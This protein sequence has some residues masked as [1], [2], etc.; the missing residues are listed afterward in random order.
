MSTIPPPHAQ[1]QMTLWN[2]RNNADLAKHVRVLKNPET[3]PGDVQTLVTTTMRIVD[4]REPNG[5]DI[6][7][8]QD[9]LHCIWSETADIFNGSSVDKDVLDAR[10]QWYTTQVS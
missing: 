4:E 6:D 8:C 9:D 10:I 3:I 1:A 7:T 5:D 2:R